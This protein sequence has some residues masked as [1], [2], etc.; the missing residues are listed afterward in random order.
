MR[1]IK[2]L[3]YLLK[4]KYY[5]ALECFK[6]GL[7]IQG[8]FHDCSK[9]WP[10]EFIPY[11]NFFYGKNG[12][13]DIRDKTGY[14]KPTDTGNK[15][16]DFAWL[17]HQK[18]NRH[19]WQWWLL[20]EDE[21]GTII[22][23]MPIKYRTEMICDWIGAGKAQGKTSPKNDPLLPTKFWYSKN[24]SKMTFGPA[25]RRYLDSLLHR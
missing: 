23:E 5:V 11:S 3:R 14:Y 15:A 25:T 10:S 19:H 7:I 17:L 2:Y 22:L 18:R 8:I 6:R 24:R 1:Y 13:K 16:F 9:L 4:H 12:V 21:G 20:P